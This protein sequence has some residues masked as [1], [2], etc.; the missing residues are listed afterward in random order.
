[1]GLKRVVR[2][3]K[4][5]HKTVACYKEEIE[6]RLSGALPQKEG[7]FASLY[8]AMEYSLLAGGKRIR[9]ILMQL[10]YEAVGGV[11]DISP[12]LCA[13]EMVH[14]YSLVHDDLPSMDN[15][16]LRRGKPTSHIVFGEAM[17]I[18][19]GDGLLNY[20][21]ETMLEDALQNEDFSKVRAIKVLAESAGV[22]GMIAGQ[23]L[24][25]QSEGK[26]INQDTL[27][28]TQ[29][30]KT[31]KLLAAATKMGAIL[32]QGSKEEVA[33]LEMYGTYLGKVFQIIDDI[34]DQTSTE[35]ELGKKTYS[36]QKNEKTTYT[37]F[38]SQEECYRI[39]KELTSK[40]IKA[41]AYV[42]GDTSLLE[43]IANDLVYRRS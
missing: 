10:A 19:A 30:Y 5:K 6:K 36:D 41:L 9:P 15:D 26:K 14:T 4:M 7:P 34:L 22:F 32:G 13:I 2:I 23:T 38:Y 28:M 12:Y 8:E 25:M 20:A 24:D 35:E 37:T 42:S 27:E 3:K 43:E 21:F 33:A 40:A 29:L 1:M 39:A 17:A 31:G 16:E 11:E 18:L